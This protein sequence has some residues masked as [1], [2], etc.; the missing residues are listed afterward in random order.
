MHLANA[1][2]TPIVAIF[3]ARNPRGIWF[4]FGQEKFVI[5]HEVSCAGCQLEACVEQQMRCIRSIT[6][7]EVVARINQRLALSTETADG[8]RARLPG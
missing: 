1:V 3:S 2:D 6:V 5:Y 7:D 8:D 4:P